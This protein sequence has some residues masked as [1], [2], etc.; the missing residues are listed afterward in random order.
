MK[1]LGVLVKRKNLLHDPSH[2]HACRLR[3]TEPEQRMALDKAAFSALHLLPK[4]GEGLKA[5]TSLLGYLNKCRTVMGTRLLASWV[6]QPLRDC[7]EISAR[8]DMVEY[9]MEQEAFR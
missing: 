3:S 5:P 1:A 6:S 4:P 8:H 7:A 9:L 2:F